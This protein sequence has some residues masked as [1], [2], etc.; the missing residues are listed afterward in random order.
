MPRVVVLCIPVAFNVPFFTALA[1]GGGS[2]K[3]EQ[4]PHLQFQQLICRAA[5]NN[6]VSCGSCPCLLFCCSLPSLPPSHFSL[7]TVACCNPWMLVLL[8]SVCGEVPNFQL[9]EKE[10]HWNVVISRKETVLV[11]LNFTM[12]LNWTETVLQS[13]MVKILLIHPFLSLYFCISFLLYAVTCNCFSLSYI[14]FNQMDVEHS[15]PNTVVSITTKPSQRC[16]PSRGPLNIPLPCQWPELIQSTSF[17]WRRCQW[18]G[19]AGKV[20]SWICKCCALF[21]RA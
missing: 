11:L 10:L 9:S 6:F 2:W 21:M 3:I 16:L 13:F 5:Q 12:F 18:V 7:S 8:L 19:V 17:T 15:R 20:P 1:C 4:V 14:N